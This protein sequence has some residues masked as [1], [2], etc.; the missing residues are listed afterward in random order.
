MLLPSKKDIAELLGKRPEDVKVGIWTSILDVCH[1]GH[2]VAMK[3]AKEQVDYLIVGIVDDPTKDRSWKN[4]PVQSLLER[5]IAAATCVY[6]DCVIPLSHE[7]DLEDCLLLLQPDKRF[8]GIE[9]K[10]R[11]FTGKDIE[12]I[13]IVYLERKHYFSSSDLRKRVLAA[14]E[15][16]ETVIHDSDIDRIQYDK[17]E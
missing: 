15:I 7:R 2:L 5:Y 13:E 17:K 16:K 6:V 14:G 4:K 11:H 9:Y 8:V 12:G 3:E 1:A 10:D